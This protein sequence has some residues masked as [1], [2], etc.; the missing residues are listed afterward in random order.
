MVE[1]KKDLRSNM[2]TIR[3]LPPDV[4]M[5]YLRVPEQAGAD[6]DPLKDPVIVHYAATVKKPVDAIID[7]N[8]IHVYGTVPSWRAKLRADGYEVAGD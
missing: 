6:Y 7:P 1:V 5:K 3:G 8:C 4:G 2:V